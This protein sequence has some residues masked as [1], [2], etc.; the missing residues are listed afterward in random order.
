M[1]DQPA[2]THKFELLLFPP[3]YRQ[4]AG[5]VRAVRDQ[6]VQDPEIVAMP[7]ITPRLRAPAIRW[8][9]QPAAR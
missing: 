8:G 7:S 9:G 3:G 6:R 2:S 5:Q 1:A 4:R